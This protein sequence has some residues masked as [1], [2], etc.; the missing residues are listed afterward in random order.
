MGKIRPQSAKSKGR[1]LQHWV[2]ELI[3]TLTGYDWGPD[4]PIESRPMGQSGPDVRLEQCVKECF[5]FTVECKW[6]E[7]WAIQQWIDQARKYPTR[8]GITWLLFLK[9]NNNNP[10]V[11]MDAEKFFELLEKVNE[12]ERPSKKNVGPRRKTSPTK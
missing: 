4:C 11:V 6:Q 7:K 9:R 1:R 12:K 5:P 3:S 10:V 2:C 8:R